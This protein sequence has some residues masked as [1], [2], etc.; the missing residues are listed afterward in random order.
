MGPLS[1]TRAAPPGYHLPSGARYHSRRISISRQPARLP[2][3]TADG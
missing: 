1:Q 2:I 3:G